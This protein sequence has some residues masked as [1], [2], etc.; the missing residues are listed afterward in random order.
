MSECG[1]ILGK[2]ENKEEGEED[3]DETQTI[4]TDADLNPDSFDNPDDLAEWLSLLSDG[5]LSEKLNDAVASE[6]YE[7]AKVYQEELK[8]R[9]KE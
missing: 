8:K 2:A 1:L 9:K 3:F 4:Y 5:E 6:N 7:Y